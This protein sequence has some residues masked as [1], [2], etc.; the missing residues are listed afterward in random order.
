VVFRFFRVGWK[1]NVVLP[2]R[3]R[4]RGRRDGDRVAVFSQRVANLIF[5]RLGARARET[6]F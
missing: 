3:G 4:G 2:F 5:L 1:A 6:G